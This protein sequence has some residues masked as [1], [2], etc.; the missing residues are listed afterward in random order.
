MKLS[1]FWYCVLLI[2]SLWIAV[3]AFDYADYER[4]YDATGGEVFMIALPLS[5]VYWRRKTVEQEKSQ[6]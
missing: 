5:V 3:K 1:K 6:H 4:G 2:L